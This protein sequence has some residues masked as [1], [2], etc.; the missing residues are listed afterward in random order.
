MGDDLK[1]GL[2]KIFKDPVDLGFRVQGF[3]AREIWDQLFSRS[4]TLGKMNGFSYHIL[5]RSRKLYLTE[6]PVTLENVLLPTQN[7]KH[8][9]SIP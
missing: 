6:F 9:T 7:P 3:R 5:G 8:L 2:R 4:A 1:V